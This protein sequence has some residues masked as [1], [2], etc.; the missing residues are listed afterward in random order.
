MK[1][2]A[3]N[4]YLPSL[5]IWLLSGL[6]CQAPEVGKSLQGQWEFLYYE[7]LESGEV[8]LPPD[9]LPTPVVFDFEDKGRNGS[10]DGTTITNRILGR[11]RLKSDG[12]MEVKEVSGTQLGEPEWVQAL[13]PALASVHAYEVSTT[14][15][16][17]T[18][19]SGGK[20]LVFAK[21]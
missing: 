7:T 19:E 18:Y 11:Y 15:M 13:W 6:A 20:Q 4:L 8:S 10:F 1:S 2:L 21:P 5:L 9:H 12:S 14:R 3:R 16:T 17:L